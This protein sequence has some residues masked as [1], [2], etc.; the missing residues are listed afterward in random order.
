MC[1]RCLSNRFTSKDAAASSDFAEL[2]AELQS[3]RNDSTQTPAAATAT[4]ELSCA[5]ARDE[6]SASVLNERKATA[7]VFDIPD[8]AK[9]YNVSSMTPVFHVQ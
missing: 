5:F 9:S 2:T 1:C 7:A 3:I 8:A 4:A 6:E